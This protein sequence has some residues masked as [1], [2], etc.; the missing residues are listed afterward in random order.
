MFR[1]LLNSIEMLDSCC[2]IEH[3]TLVGPSFRMDSKEHDMSYR[4]L[5]K[6]IGT[7]FCTAFCIASSFLKFAIVEFIVELL[8]E[9][10]VPGPGVFAFLAGG[11]ASDL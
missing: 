3:R 1:G 5:M 2:D 11:S 4:K 8:V 7:A 10:L 9:F 6:Q